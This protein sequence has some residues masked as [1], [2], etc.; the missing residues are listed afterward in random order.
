MTE[1][2]RSIQQQTACENSVRSEHERKLSRYAREHP[3]LRILADVCRRS[4]GSSAASFCKSRGTT[5]EY[6]KYLLYSKYLN[7]PHYFPFASTRPR[8]AADRSC[9]YIKLHFCQDK[10]F[11]HGQ[12][13]ALTTAHICPTTH[14]QCRSN[15][16]KTF[17]SHPTQLNCSDICPAR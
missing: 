2:A 15:G 16:C 14:C 13:S 7:Y 5:T 1:R 17:Y 8:T 12:D 6:S 11:V 9:G 3:V 4:I 10:S